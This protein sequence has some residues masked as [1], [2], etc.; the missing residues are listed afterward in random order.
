MNNYK[1]IK[2]NKKTF[3]DTFLGSDIGVHSKGFTGVA[4]VS[5]LLSLSLLVVMYVAFRI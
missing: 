5:T 2:F 1:L 4:L 3:G